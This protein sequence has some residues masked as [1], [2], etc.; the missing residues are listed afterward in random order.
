MPSTAPAASTRAHAAAM[1]THPVSDSETMEVTKHTRVSEASNGMQIKTILNRI[2][3]QRGFVYGPIQLVEEAD[4]LALHVEI[5]PH[6]R[7]RPRCSGCGRR[8]GHYDTIGLRRFEFVPLW[9]LRV[10]F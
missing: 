1:K 4:G 7:S 6:A 2:Q 10:F 9:G 5:Y 3:K 8:G